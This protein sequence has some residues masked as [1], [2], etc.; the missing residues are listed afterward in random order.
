MEKKALFSTKYLLYYD[1]Y[2]RSTIY[3][4]DCSSRWKVTGGAIYYGAYDG[5]DKWYM[6]GARVQKA[7]QQY[8][9]RLIT[10]EICL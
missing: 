6:C 10:S 8:L 7:Y 4:D 1:D 9:L 5:S 3:Y 2:T